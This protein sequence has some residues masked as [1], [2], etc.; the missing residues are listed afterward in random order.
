M[1]KKALAWPPQPSSQPR[2]ACVVQFPGQCPRGHTARNCGIL[3]T[4]SS[5]QSN[6]AS[7]TMPCTSLPAETQR[8]VTPNQFHGFH[9]HA[10]NV[11]GNEGCEPTLPPISR[12]GSSPRTGNCLERAAKTWHT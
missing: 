5:E 12:P 10:N 7:S 2:R 4:K 8:N 6:S 1:F 11:P 3:K 9:I